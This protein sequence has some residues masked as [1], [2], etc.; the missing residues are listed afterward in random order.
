MKKIALGKTGLEISKIFYGGI[1]STDDGQENSD[2]YVAYAIEQGINYFDVA[3]TYGDAEEKLGNSLIPYRNDVYLACKTNQRTA[4]GAKQKLAHSLELLHTDHFDV[5]QMHE[6][7]SVAE[8]ESTFAK[9]GAMEVLLKA[10]EEGV[11]KHLGVTCH[12]EEAAVRALELYDFDTVLFPTNWGLH[13]SRGFGSKIAAAC[14]EKQVG[15]LG[16]KSM[17][18]R[19]WYDQAE[20]DASRFLKSWCKPIF[21][22]DPLTIAAMKYTLQNIGPCALVPPGNFENFKFAV[23]HLEQ[24]EQPLTAEELAMLEAELKA[25]HPHYFF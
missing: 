12:S 20:R 2:R 1:V 15:F 10:K 5:Y 22:N 8:L 11:A 19:A 21:D 4:E 7:S 13:M 18:H 24:I 9:G 25:I 17:V 23:E 6:I 16:M 14:A 3:P